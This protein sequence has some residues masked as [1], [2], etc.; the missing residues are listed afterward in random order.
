MER[1]QVQNRTAA[2]LLYKKGMLQPAVAMAVRTTRYWQRAYRN[3]LVQ[4][5]QL[6]SMMADK[7][8]TLGPY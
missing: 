1:Y 4:P 2:L 7:G 3:K 6:Q 5:E 8:R